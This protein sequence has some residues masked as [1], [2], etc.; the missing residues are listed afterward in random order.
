[1]CST[2][3]VPA[4]PTSLTAKRRCRLKWRCAVE[5]AFGV[6]METLLAM[7]TWHDIHAIRQ[8]A[9]EIVVRPYKPQVPLRADVADGA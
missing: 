7:Q 2:C 3:S 5:Q 9:G 8:R 6:K 4:C 1:M